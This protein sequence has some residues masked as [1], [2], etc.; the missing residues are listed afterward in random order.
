MEVVKITNDGTR[1]CLECQ[2][3]LTNDDDDEL[4][5]PKLL[6]MTDGYA[7]VDMLRRMM[8]RLIMLLN[9]VVE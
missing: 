3:S 1:L 4:S 9:T 2:K 6:R 5:A 8:I 7:F